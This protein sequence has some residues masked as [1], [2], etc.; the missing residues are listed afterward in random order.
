MI[1]IKLT[2]LPDSL[3][4]GHTYRLVWGHG[5]C[6]R[7]V[8]FGGYLYHPV[9]RSLAQSRLWWT[10][11]SLTYHEDGSMPGC[12]RKP[13]AIVN[14]WKNGEWTGWDK[15]DRWFSPLYPASWIELAEPASV[16]PVAGEDP[17]AAADKRR[18]DL[19]REVFS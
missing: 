15:A 3:R 10:G 18:D 14:Y 9:P 12:V 1:R 7:M 11:E 13:C 5:N 17:L 8:V 2:C 16:N 4:T 6:E 19:L